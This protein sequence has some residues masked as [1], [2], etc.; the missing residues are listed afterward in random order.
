MTFLPEAVGAIGS[1]PVDTK[2]MVLAVKN[3]TTGL[4]EEIPFANGALAAGMTTVIAALAARTDTQLG[5]LTGTADGKLRGAGYNDTDGVVD[6]VERANADLTPVTVV[7]PQLTVAGAVDTTGATTPQGCSQYNM[8]TMQ[9]V[10]SGVTAANIPTY[11]FEGS[12]DSPTAAPSNWFNMDDDGAD[13]VK[14][15]DGVYKLHK[16]N[17]KCNWVRLKFVSEVGTASALVGTYVGG[18]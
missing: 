13:T 8:H 2:R 3:P 9:V 18:R 17:F 1:A 12:C 16:P 11:R 15:A 5:T 14:L 10:V 7:F 4:W 6:V